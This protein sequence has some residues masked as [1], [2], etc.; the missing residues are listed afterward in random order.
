M[1][2]IFERGDLD[3]LGIVFEREEEADW[4]VDTL[5]EDMVD[6][7]TDVV[8]EG[9]TPEQIHLFTQM[10]STEQVGT[11]LK[12]YAPDYKEITENVEADVKRELLLF[13]DQLPGTKATRC[14]EEDQ[15]DI[16]ALNL[17]LRNRVSLRGADINTVGALAA[18]I[19]RL[20][21]GLDRSG[22][23]RVI[24]ALWDYLMKETDTRYQ[25]G[26][27]I[28]HPM[29][30]TGTI[31]G[32]DSYNGRLKIDFGEHGVKTL[33]TDWVEKNCKEHYQH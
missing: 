17:T 25:V 33:G 9:K 13:R 26:T 5:Q 20:P 14:F 23:T 10:T 21:T 18:S 32:F 27:A 3:R 11:W 22:R 24:K 15:S 2:Y 19:S 29:F 28:R 1:A 4:L 31:Q 7:I 8:A 30:G 6:R 12:E 16:N